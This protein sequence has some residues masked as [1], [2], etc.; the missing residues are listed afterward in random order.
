MKKLQFSYFNLIFKKNVELRSHNISDRQ[1]NNI[2]F[3]FDWF[4]RQIPKQ[5]TTYAHTHCT[6]FLLFLIILFSDTTV[7]LHV[8]DLNF[9]S[10]FSPL[11]KL[12]TRKLIETRSKDHWVTCTFRQN[13]TII[14]FLVSEPMFH[15]LSERK[16]AG[17]RSNRKT[18][19]K[20]IENTFK[21]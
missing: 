11:I 1:N 21:W 3:R 8:Y 17:H 19:T 15:S 10:A 4:I 13:P 7:L 2:N 16:L 5:I 6:I 14:V 20:F 9:C 18:Q 12:Y